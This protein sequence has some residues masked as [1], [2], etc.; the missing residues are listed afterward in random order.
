MP[1]LGLEIRPLTEAQRPWLTALL[2]AR[3]GGT[4][5]VSAGR[6]RDAAALPALVASRGDGDPLG[7][8]VLERRDDDYELVVLEALRPGE[9]IGTALLD[10]TIAR[11]RRAR[12]RRVWLVTTNDNLRALRF[13]QRRGLRLVALRPGAVDAARELKPSIPLAGEDGIEIHDEL[14]LEVAL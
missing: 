9:G 5:I 3:W 6:A 12:C 10:A 11:A 1:E 13:Y 4:T 14:E 8:A 2:A 7:V